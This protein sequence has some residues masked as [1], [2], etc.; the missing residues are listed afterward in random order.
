MQRAA[1]QSRSRCGFGLLHD[2]TNGWG[3][4]FAFLAVTVAVIL[5]AGLRVSRPDMLED[6][7]K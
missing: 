7:W 3:V 2:R 4:P 6:T 1:C 5:V